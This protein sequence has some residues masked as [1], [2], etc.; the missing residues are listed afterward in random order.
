MTIGIGAVGP[1]A[2]LA[3]FRTLALAE[4]IG[5]GA[6]GG[7][8]VFAAID[9]TGT[10]HRAETQRG[11]SRTLFTF[12]ETTGV[13]PPEEIASA[14]YAA[15]MSSGPDRPAPLMQFLPG[16]GSVGLVTG[17]RLPN[18]A[19]RDGRAL[20]VAVLNAMRQG[21]PAERAL[22][23]VLDAE[24][25][26][27][28]GMIALGPDRGIAM[29]NSQRVERRPDL[30]SSLL[31]SAGD[32][33]IAILH[34]AI[35]P[36][37]TLA[38]LL[39]EAGLEMMTATRLPAGRVE[40]KAGTPLLLGALDCVI[41]DEHNMVLRVETT[42]RRIVTGI[43]NCA[44]IYVGAR[45]IRGGDVLGVTLEEPNT[46]VENGRIVSLSGQ[47]HFRIG[48]ART[49]KQDGGLHVHQIDAGDP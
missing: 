2:G 20:N 11:G 40:V 27:D 42:D 21:E 39:A 26:A 38:P 7:Y 22:R 1:N 17:H 24:P 35:W 48:Y 25:D 9:R 41:V 49:S 43:H 37:G 32:A 36:A 5:T 14:P 13:Q 31:R 28:A 44:A 33:A 34:N 4:R 3:V 18:A 29:L 46:M 45:V 19:G 16:D 30:G 23:T 15:V 10:L 6:I 47:S 12:A 8:A